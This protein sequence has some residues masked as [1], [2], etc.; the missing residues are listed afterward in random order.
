M[1]PKTAVFCHNGLGDGI[2][3]LVLSNNLQLN[4]YEVHTYQN[5]LGPLQNWFP[6]LPVLSYPSLEELPKILQ[7]YDLFFVVWNDTSEFVKRLI[8][9]G[10]RRFP[11]RMKVL[12]LYSSPNIVNEPYYL[13]CLTDPTASVT[14]NMRIVCERVMHLPK[15]TKSNG[16]I[17]PEGLLFR[18]FPKRVVI[19]P[20]SSAPHKNWSKDKFVKLA[21]HL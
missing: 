1:S 7:T 15:I 4:G 12:Y 19:H 10:K 14:K 9:E 20:T 6:H 2:N 8:A 16:F 18:K 11:E 5:A 13:D 17:V 3:C 21:L